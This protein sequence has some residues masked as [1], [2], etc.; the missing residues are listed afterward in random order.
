MSQ[1]EQFEIAHK[2]IFPTCQRLQRER[3]F[4]GVNPDHVTQ[5]LP[6]YKAHILAAVEYADGEFSWGDIVERLLA[7]SWQLWVTPRSCAITKIRE[8]AQYDE[9][10]LLY[11]GMSLAW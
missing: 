7:A 11:A 10:V 3:G 9:C 5:V 4:S 8:Q 2:E 6:K 1:F